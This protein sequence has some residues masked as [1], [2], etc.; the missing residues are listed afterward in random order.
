M[1]ERVSQESMLKKIFPF[2]GWF[3]NYRFEYFKADFFA[4][5]SVAL[6]LIP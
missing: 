1:F 2:L 3:D 4:G 5:I 6:V